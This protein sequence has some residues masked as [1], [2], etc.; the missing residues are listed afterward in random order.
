MN[1]EWVPWDGVGQGRIRMES[2]SGAV[3][4]VFRHELA[5]HAAFIL[6]DEAGPSFRIEI[7]AA[8][9]GLK[10]RGLKD[11]VGEAVES[12]SF[13]ENGTERLHQVQG[14]GPAAVFCDV[15]ETGGRIQAMGMQEGSDFVVKQSGPKGEASVDR[16]VRG[17]AGAALERE[18]RREKAGPDFKIAG[19]CRPLTSAQFIDG[20]A[21]GG[22][23]EHG[24]QTP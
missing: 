21:S 5:F 6:E 9:R 13:R 24:F 16:I 4:G 15:E 19:G 10:M 8:V 12:E 11:L 20:P 23:T 22:G 1:D 3:A 17:A 18:F 2:G 7:N 14:K